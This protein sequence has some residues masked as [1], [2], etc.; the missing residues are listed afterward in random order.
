MNVISPIE[1]TFKDIAEAAFEAGQNSVADVVL[2][3][4]DPITWQLGT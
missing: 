3:D 2:D 1:S 4:V